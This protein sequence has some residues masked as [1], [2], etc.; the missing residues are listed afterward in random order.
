MGRSKVS[1]LGDTHLMIDAPG[2][3]PKPNGEHQLGEN[4]VEVPMA[5]TTN[6]L[7]HSQGDTQGSL[8]LAIDHYRPTIVILISNPKTPARKFLDWVKNGNPEVGKWSGDVKHCELIEIEPFSESSV[9]EM[10]K[11]VKKAKEWARNLAPNEQLKFYAGVAGGTKLMV[12]GMALAAIQGD[13]TTYY[14]DNPAKSNRNHGEYVVEIAFMNQVMT[15]SSWLNADDRRLKN[16]NYLRVIQT[17]EKRGLQSTSKLMD[18]TQMEGPFTEDEMRTTI[19]RVQDNITKQLKMLAGK[20]MVSYE[21]NNPRYWQLTD[22]GEFILSIYG[23]LPES[24][25]S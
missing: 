14:V 13:L 15:A 17:R 21:G 18:R 8:K 5:P 10:I 22:L 20:G 24:N 4:E 23:E 12:I 7:I 16:L 9:L 2:F 3:E 6:V 19:M 11:A 1:E 25:S